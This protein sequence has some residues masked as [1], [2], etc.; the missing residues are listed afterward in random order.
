MSRPISDGPEPQYEKVVSGYETFHHR[1]RF[2]C[3]WGGELSELSLAYET[4]GELSSARDNAVLVH[5]GLSSSSDAQSQE[6]Y[7]H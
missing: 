3:D 7:P 6:K 2:T 4:W 5:T 1:E